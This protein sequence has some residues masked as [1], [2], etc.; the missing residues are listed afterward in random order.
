MKTRTVE[1]TF[2]G[3]EPLLCILE[4]HDLGQ[5]VHFPSVKWE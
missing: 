3:P 2:L 4:L 5:I 1:P